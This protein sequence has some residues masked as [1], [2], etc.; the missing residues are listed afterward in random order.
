MRKIIFLALSFVFCTANAQTIFGFETTIRD[1][2]DIATETVGDITLT[3]TN[4][5]LGSLYSIRDNWNG[6]HGSSGNVLLFGSTTS[7][8]FEFSQTVDVHSIIPMESTSKDVIYLFARHDGSG[9]SPVVVSLTGG[10]GPQSPLPVDLNWEDVTTFTVSA[11]VSSLMAFDT[12]SVSAIALSVSD[13]YKPLKNIQV[14][15]NPT[16]NS[17]HIKHDSDIKSINIYNSLGQHVLQ[18]K[19]ASIDVSHLSKGMYFLKIRTTGG[20]ETKKIIKM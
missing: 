15:P 5:T 10:G 16:I 17:I 19:Q 4:N 7:V 18:S 9:V 6:W 20:T 14:Y 13:H 2:S 8:T 11:S 3:A 1:G 12:L